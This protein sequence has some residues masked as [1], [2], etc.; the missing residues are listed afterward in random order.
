GFAFGVAFL[1]RPTNILFLAPLIFCVPLRPRTIALFVLG[2]LPLAGVFLSYNF[3]V[4]GNPLQTGYGNIDLALRFHRDGMLRRM[5]SYLYWMAVTLSPLVLAGWLMAAFLRS[6]EWRRRAVLIAW[7]APFLLLYSAYDFY[8]EWWY[9]RFL[10]PAYPALI[11]GMLLTAQS[12]EVRMSRIR[13]ALRLATGIAVGIVLLWVPLK[14]VYR[15][16]LLAFGK[17]ESLHAES[18]RWADSQLPAGAVIVATEMSGALH[19]YT[20]RLIIRHERV[21]RSFWP[22]L[23][24]RVIDSGYEFYALLKDIELTGAKQSVPGRWTELGHRR[25]I[26]LWRIEPLEG[27]ASEVKYGSGFSEIERTP[28]GAGWR[29]MSDEGVVQLRNTGRAMRLRIEGAVPMYAFARPSTLQVILNGIVLDTVAA[30][31]EPLLREYRIATSQ[32]H[33]GEWTELRLVV[34]QAMTPNEIDHR[35]PDKRRLGFSLAGL[36]W[37]EAPQ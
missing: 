30:G 35:N 4:F 8:D 1:V 9:T 5:N 6:V 3:V 12:L 37:D 24:R 10:L 29:W 13:P 17:S 31:G 2:G 20:D 27:M 7:F 23:R 21:V 26:G 16:N 22:M 11:L 19:F 14:Y 32:Q 28:G 18:C 33:D 25:H 36:L 15:H 34:D